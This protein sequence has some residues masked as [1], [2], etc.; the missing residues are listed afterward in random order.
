MLRFEIYKAGPGSPPISLNGAHLIG[1]EGIPLRAEITLQDNTVLC[2]KRTPGAASLSLLWPVPTAGRIM[3]ETARVPERDEPYILN[4]ELARGR[5]MRIAQ[6]QEDWGLFDQTGLEDLDRHLNRARDLFIEALK[7]DERAEAAKL[8]DESLSVAVPAS[9]AMA[10]FYAD[11]VLQIYRNNRAK[12]GVELPPQKWSSAAAQVQELAEV[13]S[14]RMPWRLLQPK[15]HDGEYAFDLVDEQISW[16]TRNRIAVMAGPLISFAEDHTPDWLILYENDYEA[17]R[18]LTLEHIR[19]V[20]RR[21]KEHV[22]YWRVVSGLHAGNS[23]TFT[24]EQIM[25]LTRLAIAAT[26][27]LAPKSTALVEIVEPWG[28]YYA[29]KV[30]TIPPLIYADLVLQ[31]GINADGFAV[32]LSQGNAE[33]GGYARDLFAVSILLDRLTALGKPVHISAVAVPSQGRP[34]PKDRSAGQ[35]D[36]QAAGHWRNG[37]NEQTQ[38]YWAANFYRIAISKPL[39]ESIIWEDFCDGFEHNTPHGG[40]LR[41]DGSPK[42]VYEELVSLKRQLRANQTRRP[43]AKSR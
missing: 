17:I 35:V 25:E 32:R 23:M 31:S 14:V 7:A 24:F 20:V 43:N 41:H 13:A 11:Q 16:L 29:R 33:V 42:P 9:E 12:L 22:R 5:L 4:L 30:R 28:E 6:K 40:L 38:A 8:A 27:E 26:K 18:D 39:L 3:L 10:R 34:D 2:Q 37:W 36:P 15:E 1:S 21:Y 19:K